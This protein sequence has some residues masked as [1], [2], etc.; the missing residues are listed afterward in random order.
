[1]III[2]KAVEHLRKLKGSPKI[3]IEIYGNFGDSTNA[4][5]IARHYKLK[6]QNCRIVF[7]TKDNYI[8]AYELNR[9]FDALFA[10]PSG[11]S[12]QERIKI[13]DYIMSN[14]SDIEFKLCPSI[15]PYGEVWRSHKWSLPVISHQFFSNAKIDLKEM[16]GD[17]KLHI[18]ISNDDEKF[19]DNFINGRKC[20][21]LEYVSYSHEPFWKLNDFKDF[22]H[23]M[24]NNGFESITFAGPNE[25]IIPGTIDGRGVTWRRTVAIMAR[26]RYMV[27]IGSGLT[28]LATAARPTPAIIELGVSDSISMTSCGYANS[29]VLK[30]GPVDAAA[31]IA[32]AERNAK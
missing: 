12:P 7:L 11:L 26:C 8:N 30:C 18:P 13:G 25:G 1:M 21:C 19:A 5:A 32:N 27:G 3:L 15:F 22:V 24:K 20:I 9:D 28:M 10:L 2:D 23:L 4:T 6:Y 16:L 31:Y 17:K 29:F 14:F